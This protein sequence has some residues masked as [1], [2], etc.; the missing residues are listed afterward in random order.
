MNRRT[1]R[2]ADEEREEEEEEMKNEVLTKWS[3]GEKG[4]TG[5]KGRTRESSIDC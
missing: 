2:W 4:V 5:A 1:L 3:K